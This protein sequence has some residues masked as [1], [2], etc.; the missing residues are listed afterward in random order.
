MRIRYKRALSASRAEVI[1]DKSD[2]LDIRGHNNIEDRKPLS[3][4]PMAWAILLVC[5]VLLANLAAVWKGVFI[6]GREHLPDPDHGLV[7]S[8]PSYDFGTV[9]QGE[10]LKHVFTLS[11]HSHEPV[12][13]IRVS[14]SCSCTIPP[15]S[16]QGRVLDVGESCEVPLSVRTGASNGESTP[17]ANLFLKPVSAKADSDELRVT[18]PL[19][20]DVL[21]D[22]HVNPTNI[23]LGVLDDKHA[24]TRVVRVYGDALSNVAITDTRVSDPMI[25][26]G[27]PAIESHKPVTIALPITVKLGAP[28]GDPKHDRFVNE[29]LAIT[30]NSTRVPTTWISIRG[31]VQ[32]E[33]RAEPSALVFVDG[34]EPAKPDPATRSKEIVL[35]AA[36][37]FKVHRHDCKN[38]DIQATPD[39]SL[40][41]ASHA[42]RVATRATG[43]VKYP[44]SARLE[45][46]CASSTGALES[47]VI[48]VYFVSVSIKESHK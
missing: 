46:T 4:R 33:I 12:R 19:R 27:P 20:V 11:N 48:P 2:K 25:T 30:T 35:S 18:L 16:L 17:F 6:S 23:D 45:L 9:K 42:I 10:T 39:N 13:I 14:A 8:P 40:Q 7:I 34:V 28:D 38:C 43:L 5:A 36:H 47:V 29:N 24:I 41:A 26:V 1:G 31:I 37:P 44:A 22:Y 21:P 15:T 3:E 32:R